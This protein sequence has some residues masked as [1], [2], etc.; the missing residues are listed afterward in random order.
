MSR[1]SVRAILFDAIKIRAHA[2]RFIR[3]PN[4]IEK[5]AH[6]RAGFRFR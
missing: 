1:T 3:K 2:F 6:N 5:P 4:H